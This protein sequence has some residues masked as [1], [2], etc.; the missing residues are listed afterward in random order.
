[1]GDPPPLRLLLVAWMVAGVQTQYQHLRARLPTAV[2]VSAIETDPYVPG[3]RIER[4]PLPSS[5][6]GTLRSTVTLLGAQ[7]GPLPDAVWSQVALPLLPFALTRALARRVPI[8]YAID[9]TPAL[10]WGFGGRYP[11]I[12]DP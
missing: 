1:M 6:R 2:R 9:C 7:R 8:A 10:L 4:L 12:A 5:V 11:G 3:G